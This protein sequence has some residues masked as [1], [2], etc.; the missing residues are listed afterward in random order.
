[1]PSKSSMLRLLPVSRL[2]LLVLLISCHP[3]ASQAQAV[4]P[5]ISVGKIEQHLGVNNGCALIVGVNYGTL[6]LSQLCNAITPEIREKIERVASIDK[7]VAELQREVTASS[8][9]AAAS[10][11]TNID[12]PKGVRRLIEKGQISDAA[13]MASRLADVAAADAVGLH[14]WAC[15]LYANQGNFDSALKQIV[16]A[17]V[18]DPSNPEL[19]FMHAVAIN[20]YSLSL[21]NLTQK[22]LELSAAKKVEVETLDQS[23][24]RVRAV[25][26]GRDPDGPR[27]TVADKIAEGL[28]ENTRH[29]EELRKLFGHQGAHPANASAGASASASA[30]ASERAGT[31]VF[32]EHGPDST[33][34]TPVSVAMREPSPELMSAW[35]ESSD[36]LRTLSSEVTSVIKL[37]GE[38]DLA[39]RTMMVEAVEQFRLLPDA[40]PAIE[41]R[42]VLAEAALLDRAGDISD[43]Y[44]VALATDFE[45]RSAR[46]AKY[47]GPNFRAVGMLFQ[48]LPCSYRYP[49]NGDEVHASEQV[50]KSEECSLAAMGRVEDGLQTAAPHDAR[51][52]M[53]LALLRSV[54]ARDLL[55][56]GRPDEALTKAQ[57]AVSY[58][59][60]V[61]ARHGQMEL[62]AD[63]HFG[64]SRLWLSNA[65]FVLADIHAARKQYTQSFVEYKEATN[66]YERLAATNLSLVWKDLAAAYYGLAKAEEA[67]GDVQQALL[68]HDKSISTYARAHLG[69][70]PTPPQLLEGYSFAYLWKFDLTA[71]STP[72]CDL[73]LQAWSVGRVV[74]RS[75]VK[76]Y[77]RKA[78]NAEQCER[79]PLKQILGAP[80]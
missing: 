64:D 39:Y 71:K 79:D 1:M 69:I 10:A 7:K 52:A 37:R 74:N 3:I 21:V 48:L 35:S 63:I 23:V 59:R 56:D 4:R 50:K 55:E 17:R 45:E 34:S 46:V 36:S 25:A 67:S 40:D 61:I 78:V 22:L 68:A 33:N 28:A 32:V 60:E 11:E 76:M 57:F 27:L 44:Y 72:H 20:A 65:V 18:L 42:L 66:G 38:Q 15:L 19:T 58:L 47:L 13:A 8:K 73:I 9:A 29:I 5:Q 12:S 16:A 51:A 49:D 75:V 62:P 43:A 6:D 2:S 77:A 14:L 24:Q 70:H 54:T 80:V 53:F 31:A 26:A 41:A 30:S